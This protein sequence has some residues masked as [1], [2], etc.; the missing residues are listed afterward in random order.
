MM[1]SAPTR[2]GCQVAQAGFE[3]PLCNNMISRQM[4]GETQHRLSGRQVVRILRLQ[5]RF[6]GSR[7]DVERTV[8]VGCPTRI[9][10]QSV[11]KRELADKVLLSML[12]FQPG[13][14]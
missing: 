11:Q 14:R 4:I 5:S 13:Q 7:G 8:N 2:A 6:L 3:M 9:Q 12:I 1:S 10:E